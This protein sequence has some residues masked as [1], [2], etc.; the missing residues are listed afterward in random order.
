M[1]I[2]KGVYWESEDFILKKDKLVYFQQ[3]KS[4][5]RITD[6]TV[7]AEESKQD[8]SL[9]TVSFKV[10]G[11][12]HDVKVHVFASNSIFADAHQFV[13]KYENFGSPGHPQNFLFNK[14]ENQYM[15]N[16][17]LGDELRY[18]LERKYLKSFMGTNLEK[19]GL[20]FKKKYV[21]D[22]YFTSAASNN[23]QNYQNVVQSRCQNI[24][25]RVIPTSGYGYNK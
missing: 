3:K 24:Q 11:A 19:P 7:D 18:A 14:N 4:L 12:S 10:D 16:K 22:T 2:H 8:E 1:T 6:Y 25:N 15:S 23:E 9:R 20:L 21:A 5:K 13:M 17:K